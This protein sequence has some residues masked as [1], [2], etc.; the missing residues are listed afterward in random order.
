[1]VQEALSTAV[2]HCVTEIPKTGRGLLVK[3][4]SNTG[5]RLLCATAGVVEAAT[6]CVPCLDFLLGIVVLA[7]GSVRFVVADVWDWVDSGATRVKNNT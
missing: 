2:R 6:R 5:R 4:C 3:P 1:M 7:N